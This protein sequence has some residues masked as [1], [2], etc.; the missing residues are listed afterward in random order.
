MLLDLVALKE[1]LKQDVSSKKICD[2]CQFKDGT[3]VLLCYQAAK[4]L[5]PFVDHFDIMMKKSSNLFLHPLDIRLRI[6]VATRTDLTLAHI[7]T[8]IW[9]PVFDSCRKLLDTLIDQTMTLSYIDTHLKTYSEE[10]DHV[11]YNLA[12]GLSKC[13]AIPPDQTRLRRSLLSI[14]QYWKLCEY[15]AGAQVFLH[16][17]DVLKLKG[18]FKLVERFSSQV[19]SQR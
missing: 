13:L 11:V 16:L 1:E 8:E 15:Q 9:Q 14:H 2:L 6:T 12:V 19:N 7:H 18:D 10:L 17:R 5:D 4:P 3:P